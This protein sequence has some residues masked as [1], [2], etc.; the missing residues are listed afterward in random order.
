[1]P[2]D[3]IS[4]ASTATTGQHPSDKAEAV[5]LFFK[6]TGRLLKR[7]NA[8]ITRADAD[9]LWVDLLYPHLGLLSIRSDE[10]Q[11]QYMRTQLRTRQSQTV[12]T[13]K[14]DGQTTKRLLGK[15]WQVKGDVVEVTAEEI[16]KLGL[17]WD[18]LPPFEIAPWDMDGVKIYRSDKLVEYAD[19]VMEHKVQGKGFDGKMTQRDLFASLQAAC[20]S[21]S[22]GV[23]G[24]FNRDA[25]QGKPGKDLD[26]CFVCDKEGIKKMGEHAESQGWEY[27]HLSER[28]R[29]VAERMAADTGREL[30]DCIDEVKDPVSDSVS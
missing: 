27:S 9:K 29:K 21:V 28:R 13:D 7:E 12:A 24:G 25:M 14:Q 18:Y 11:Q 4:V 20:P 5:D 23:I 16:K 10:T 15:A 26:V 1:M 6:K 2:G 8:H 30:Q 17:E 3:S 22:I 19:T